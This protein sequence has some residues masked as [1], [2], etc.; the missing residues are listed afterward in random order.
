MMWFLQILALRLVSLAAPLVCLV[1]QFRRGW[2]LT[3]DDPVSPY[4]QGEPAMRER[5]AKWG[6]YWSDWWWLAA[7]N[8]AYGLAYAFKPDFFK[9][10][11]T[12]A[13][14]RPVVT[15][16]GPLRVIEIAGFREYMLSLRWFHIIAGYRLRP[17]RDGI[18]DGAPYRAVNMDARP[19]LSIRAGK[20]DD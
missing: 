13:D 12:Y 4:G 17:V 16:K 18:Y 5:L 9:Q 10:L 6:V 11:T 1:P 14:L 3:P 15:Y 19:I 8:R 2:F 7:R 20:A